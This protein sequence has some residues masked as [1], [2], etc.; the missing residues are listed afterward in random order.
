MVL[1]RILQDLRLKQIRGPTTGNGGPPQVAVFQNDLNGSGSVVDGH[2]LNPRMRTEKLFA[3]SKRDRVR[4]R[5]ANVFELCA[6][7]S[8]QGLIDAADGLADDRQFI[9][10]QQVV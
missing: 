4:H 2:R 6:R 10:E 7:Q 9:F 5:A 3:L 1:Y 8:D